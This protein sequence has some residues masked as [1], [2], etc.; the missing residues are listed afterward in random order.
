MATKEIIMSTTKLN[1]SFGVTHAVINLDITIEKGDIMGLV[2]EN[3]AGK[4]TLIKILGGEYYLDSGQITYQNKII[5]WNSS[6]EALKKGIA[7]VHQ[8]PLL[9]FSLNAAENIFLGK[10]FTQ[11]IFLDEKKSI[12][13]SKK[14][15]KQY[16]IYPELDLEK[17]VIEMSAGEKEVVE[18]LK[19]LSYNPKILILDEPTASLP[20][21]EAESLLKLLVDLNRKKEMTMIYISH[22]LEETFEICNKI[23]VMRNGENIGMLTNEHFDKNKLVKMMI[24]QDI[25]EFYPEKSSQIGKVLLEANHINSKVLKD[26]SIHVHEGEIV[27]LYGLIGAG[28]TE[29]VESIYGLQPFQSGEIIFNQKKILHPHVDMMVHHGIYLIPADRHQY[30]LFPS[31][32][33]SENI[34]IAHLFSLFPEFLL[35]RYKENQVATKEA[36]QMNLKYA[37]INQSIKE[38]SGGNQQKVIVAR[39]LLKECNVL[40]VDDPTVGIDI[41]AKRDIYRILRE[42]NSHHKGIIFISS[43]INEIIGMADRIYTMRRGIITAELPKDEINQE[44]ILKNI[45]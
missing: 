2:G 16:P 10:E 25:S 32:S 17:P 37:D 41:G 22:K 7:I 12:E 34:T 27:G 9:V 6:A 31:F 11:G 15:V 20:K 40:I 44:N 23:T 28:M 8:H 4:S 38:L 19:A 33:V 36:E 5:S 39:W 35:T 45:L 43:E 18:I 21:D 13:E 29:L 24:N 14:L 1:K 3:G 30:G 26:V 42:L